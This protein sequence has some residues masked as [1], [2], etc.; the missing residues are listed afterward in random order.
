M[1]R[2]LIGIDIGTTG[3]K[4][5]LFTEKGNIV[6]HSYKGY[7][8]TTPALNQCEQKA[9]DWWGAVVDTVRAI[10][11]GTEAKDNV[12]AISLSV[13]GGT[14]VPVDGE[15]NPLRPAIVWN[16][17]RC[18]IQAK[19]FANRFG[20][21]YMYEKTG[22]ALSNGLN[23]LQ[24]AWIRENEPEIFSRTDKFLSVPDYI[25]AKLTGRAALDLSNAGINQLA[26][27]VKGSYDKDILDFIEIE[28]EKLGEIIPSGEPIGYL[29]QE[30]KEELGLTGNVMFCSGAHD[31]Y[32]ALIGSGAI[33]SGDMLLGTG[34]A[35]VLTMLTDSP[36]FGD[37][38][39]QSVSAIPG[40]WGS[41]VSLPTGGISLDWLLKNV[42]NKDINI[43]KLTYKELDAQV[44]LRHPG[45]GGLMFFPYFMGAGYP[46]FDGSSKAS[47][48]GLDLSH[49]RIDMARAVMEG[50]AYQTIWPISAFDQRYKD[51]SLKISGG[52][53]KSNIWLKIVANI[54]NRP[55]SVPEIPDLTCIGAAMLA[56]LGGGLFSSPDEA[57]DALGVG[58]RVIEP[59]LEDSAK[60]T[61]LFK[62]YKDRAKM[63]SDMYKT[64]P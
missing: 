25:S 62:L 57:F 19:A 49:D 23:A 20:Q 27:I 8:V 28:E 7:P 52:A 44:A 5:I 55:I 22:W 59:D 17:M 32:A 33:N 14:L 60:Y 45:S 54:V 64:K 46:L 9:E 21:S 42:V 63:L 37:N 11:S 24:I 18:G 16:D 47:F 40:K 35:W 3:T 26:D 10:I 4:S 38:L 53:T 50:I 1:N 6:A 31:Q 30:A 43:E 41:L 29:T 13:Q 51:S 61:E 58:E 39:S 15:L 2:Y 12:A 48:I 36:N 56:G 34:T